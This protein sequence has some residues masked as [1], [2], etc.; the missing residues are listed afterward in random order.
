MRGLPFLLATSLLVMTRTAAAQSAT[1]IPSDIPDDLLARSATTGARALLARVDEVLNSIRYTI[2]VNTG[3]SWDDATGDYRV[4]CSGYMN[5]VLGDADPV[6]YDQLLAARGVT[7]PKAEDYYYFFHSIRTGKTS[8]DWTRPARM[9]DA[10]PGDL[11]VWRYRVTPSSGSTGHVMM[12][13]SVPLLYPGTSNVYRVRVSDSARSGHSNDNR[14]ST[15]S[16][17]GAGEILVKV[18][19]HGAPAE[20]AWT[21]GSLF[22]AEDLALGRAN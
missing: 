18:D 2:Y 12:V 16:G 11:L 8:G 6:A 4:D 10:R 7:W 22:H 17:V 15:T 1:T 13:A 21:L 3:Q 5:R 19:S 9:A 20:Y 14:T